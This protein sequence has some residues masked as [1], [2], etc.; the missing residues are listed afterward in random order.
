[1]GSFHNKATKQKEREREMEKSAYGIKWMFWYSRGASTCCE[2]PNRSIQHCMS[3]INQTEQDNN[4]MNVLI[5]PL[6]S[7]TK[8]HEEIQQAPFFFFKQ[9]E[10]KCLF[11]FSFFSFFFK[12][13]CYSLAFVLVWRWSRCSGRS[14]HRPCLARE[15]VTWSASVDSCGDSLMLMLPEEE[16]LLRGRGEP[17]ADTQGD[18]TT[19]SAPWS[20]RAFACSRNVSL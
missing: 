17:S 1:M 7:R 10:V 12:L 8:I 13:P 14:D 11:F 4:V 6:Q 5:S 2:R 3:S 18:L 16:T 15:A 20:V 9:T 19:M